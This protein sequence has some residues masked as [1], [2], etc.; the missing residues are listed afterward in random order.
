[1]QRIKSIQSDGTQIEDGGCATEDVRGQPHFAERRPKNLI[2]CSTIYLA[3][4]AIKNGREKSYPS[5][6]HGVNNVE[7]QNANGDG[8]VGHGQGN[9]EVIGGDFEWVVREHTDDDQNVAHHGDNDD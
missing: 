4:K 7:G 8:K 6:Q 1:M 3:L 2:K 5:T 9:D